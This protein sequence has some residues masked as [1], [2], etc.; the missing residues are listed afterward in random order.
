[1]ETCILA[2]LL[3][4]FEVNPEYQFKAICLRAL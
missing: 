2:L 1:M 4:S 3:Y